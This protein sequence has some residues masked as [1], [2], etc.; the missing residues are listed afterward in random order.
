[1]AKYLK[2]F[3]SRQVL[4]DKRNL[5]SIKSHYAA[6]QSLLG[7]IEVNGILDAGASDGRVSRK[8][9]RAFPSARAYLFEPNPLYRQRLAD[10]AQEDERIRVN[11]LALSDS[12]GMLELNINEQAGMTSIFDTNDRSA[13]LFPVGEQSQTRTSVPVTT[14]DQWRTENDGVTLELMKFD[15]Q[16]A[17]YMAL[18]GAAD[19]LNECTRLIYTEVFFNPLYEGGALF[20]D[21]DALLRHHGF[22]LYNIYKPKSDPDDMLLWANAIFVKK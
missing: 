17:E 11:E 5:V 20:G 13:E 4:G 2:N 22:V 1:M 12:P 15:I 14:I 6:M 10:Y 19:T 16:S 8:L 3:L 9:L 7:D 21:I 18:K